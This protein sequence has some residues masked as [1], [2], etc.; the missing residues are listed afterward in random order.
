VLSPLQ[1]A[2]AGFRFPS[3]VIVLAVRWYLRF[4][5]SYRDI[6]ELRTERGIQA[7]HV[8]TYWWVLRFTPLLA[9]AARPC[10]HAVG[11]P[12]AAVLPCP[13]SYSGCAVGTAPSRESPKLETKRNSWWV[14]H[15]FTR[16]RTDKN[17]RPSKTGPARL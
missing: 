1:S 6:E 5:P 11:D 13:D 2:F 4:S 12:A 10:R 8:T 7:D 16:L 14:T 3:D 9:D 17:I 15:R